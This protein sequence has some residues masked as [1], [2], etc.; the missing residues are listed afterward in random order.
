MATIS[1]DHSET[2]R[3]A[4]V[5][6]Q[7]RTSAV[8]DV[9]VQTAMAEV[10]REAFVGAGNAEA[11]Y[12]DRPLPLGGGREQNS[13]LAT[14]RLL[15]RAEILAGDRVLLIGAAGGYTAAVLAQLAAT[16]VA[17]E[18]DATLAGAARDALAGIAGVTLV[19]GPL[20]AGSADAAPFDVLIIDGAVEQLPQALVDQVRPGGRVV[21]GVVER[22]VTRLA[23]G[24]RTGGG[25]ALEPF[26][27]ID[28]VVLPGFGKARGF[29]FP[30]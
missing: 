10:P 26:A 15:T 24:V 6:S 17:V 27:D 2:A 7:L 25:F 20:E 14:G 28:C 9:R 18:S 1:P 21:S 4:M 29:Q 16:V 8:S 5:A 23:S 22:G 19:E 13:P 3:R 11:A 12:R 30:G